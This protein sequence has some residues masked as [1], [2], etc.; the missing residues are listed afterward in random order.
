MTSEKDY[1]EMLAK[2]GELTIIER[3]RGRT[4]LAISADGNILTLE[5]GRKDELLAELL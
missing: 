4:A 1:M 5:N 2:K 3:P